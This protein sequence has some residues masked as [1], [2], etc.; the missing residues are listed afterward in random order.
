LEYT[1]FG[2][3]WVHRPDAQYRWKPVAEDDIPEEERALIKKQ[4][5]RR[6]SFKMDGFD[7]AERAK[8]RK[9]AENRKT[10]EPDD[11]NEEDFV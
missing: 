2:E 8:A 10:E 4:E 1:R 11:W 9:E 6:T 3:G 7:A 5:L